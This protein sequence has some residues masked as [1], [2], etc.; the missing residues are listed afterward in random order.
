MRELAKSA[1]RYTWAMSIFGVQQAANVLTLSNGRQP[2]HRANA[3]F[4]SVEQAAENEFDDLVF[5][6]FQVGDEVQRGLTD[7]F[8]DT[9]TLQAFTPNYIS[10]LTSAVVDQS[11]DTLQ[12]YSSTESARLAWQTLKNNYEVFNLVKNASSLL[13]VPS[14]D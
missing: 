10:T 1:A 14:R 11:Q 12:T 4:F 9:L 2:G 5:A 6:A 8:F 7:I 3:A 13:H